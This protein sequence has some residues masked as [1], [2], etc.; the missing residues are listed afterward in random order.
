MQSLSETELQSQLVLELPDRHVMGAVFWVS[1][2]IHVD[3]FEG[4]LNQTFHNWSI[5]VL[6]D[7]HIQVT[8]QDDLTDSQVRLFCD[9]TATAFAA[10][11]TG[12]LI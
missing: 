8:V 10:Q 2:S 1:G 9:E 5:S 12:Q 4:L 11:C 7:N 3:L 6:D